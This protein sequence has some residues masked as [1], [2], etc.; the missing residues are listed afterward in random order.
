MNA[1]K[2]ECVYAK[3]AAGV[4]GVVGVEERA[5]VV[6]DRT[7][8]R[9]ALGVGVTCLTAADCLSVH[10]GQEFS[11][12][13]RY[14]VGAAEQTYHAR[15]LGWLAGLLLSLLSDGHLIVRHG[16]QVTVSPCV[17]VAVCSEH[18]VNL[19]DGALLLME[20]VGTIL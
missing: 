4:S 8:R 9:T 11:D 3:T 13:R 14:V 19:E 18:I 17:A 20:T 7:A 5:V 15:F 10:V 12:G 1:D 16:P 2:V 6:H